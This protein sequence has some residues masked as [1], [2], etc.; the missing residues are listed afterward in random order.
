MRLMTLA[1][2]A[3]AC[4]GLGA[5]GQKA[6][7][8][9]P[10]T[11]G[12]Q[13]SGGCAAYKAGENGIIRTFCDGPAKVTVTVDGKPFNLTGGECSFEAGMAALNVGVV[14]G[15]PAPSPLPDYVGLT[16]MKGYG[17]F[18]D[19]ALPMHLGGQDFIVKPNSGTFSAQGGTFE[20][21]VFGSGKTVS[22][23]FTC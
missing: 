7:A 8:P 9:A 2:L 14:S 13:A 11:P 18:T 3:A 21:T 1:A 6:A 12:A 16:A 17:A 5:C 22:G 4:A 20:G 19:A 10:S 15:S 23:S